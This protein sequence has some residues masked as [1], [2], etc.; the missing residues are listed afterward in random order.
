E[1]EADAGALPLALLDGDVGRKSVRLGLLRRVLAEPLDVAPGFSEL[2]V[3]LLEGGLGAVVLAV[4]VGE[5]LL[6]GG[7]LLL[8]LLDIALEASDL[9]GLG[10]GGG[11]R[12]WLGRVGEAGGQDEQDKRRHGSST[13]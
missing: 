9:L 10:A 4:G 1:V 6:D 2:L 3:G 5:L 13:T 12:G 11:G 8:A 7:E